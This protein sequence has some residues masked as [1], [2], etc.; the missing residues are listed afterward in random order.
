MHPERYPDDAPQIVT[1]PPLT[2]T[3]GAGWRLV[4]EDAIGEFQLQLYLK[5]HIASSEAETAAE[6]WG[7]DRFAVYWREDE[8]ASVLLLRLAWDTPTDA[9]EFF[10]AY[11][12]FA[13]H[14]FGGGPTRTA[15]DAR[16]WWF[17]QDALLLTQN[18]QNETLVII[19]PDKATL[20]A[21]HALFPGF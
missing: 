17:G 20:E 16:R 4:D 3:L 7:G 21:V 19:A 8:S 12:R 14:R 10:D 2:D 11:A 18:D 15:G 9:T 6:G 13:E 1:L 5:V